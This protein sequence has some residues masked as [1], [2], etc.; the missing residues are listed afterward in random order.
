MLPWLVSLW[1]H[2]S[3]PSLPQA[4]WVSSPLEID[5]ALA[6]PASTTLLSFSTGI[7]LTAGRAVLTLER[8]WWTLSWETTESHNA[9]RLWGWREPLLPK[10]T[11]WQTS[12]LLARGCFS[13]QI[14]PWCRLTV[15]YIRLSNAQAEPLSSDPGSSSLHG[16]L[17]PIL[18]AR[19]QQPSP[20]GKVSG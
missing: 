3:S 11:D 4:C 8:Q 1:S 16:K 6:I 2:P 17:P 12:D 10:G 9:L 18:T 20:E 14:P 19:T 5:R 7:T 15:V 13:F